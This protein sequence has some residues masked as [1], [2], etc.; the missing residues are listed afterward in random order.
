[1]FKEDWPHCLL[2]QWMWLCYAW[3][4]PVPH[5]TRHGSAI[6]KPV[7][8]LQTLPCSHWTGQ[9]RN[10]DIHMY[11]HA[12]ANDMAPPALSF[13]TWYRTGQ[14]SPMDIHMYYWHG[15]PTCPMVSFPRG[16]EGDSPVDVY[17]CTTIWSSLGK[18]RHVWSA[19]VRNHIETFLINTNSFYAGLLKQNLSVSNTYNSLQSY[20]IFSNNMQGDIGSV[21]RQIKSHHNYYAVDRF[22]FTQN[23]FGNS[24]KEVNSTQVMNTIA[25]SINF[26]FLVLERNL[27]HS[28]HMT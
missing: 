28:K 5:E 2:A 14:H 10:I 4:C 23:P 7:Y 11:S 16:T 8:P 15:C 26:G 13:P 3:P 19:L 20:L 9:D 21:C 1:M 24:G 17:R 25:Q 6:D 27:H 18:L 12:N 22:V